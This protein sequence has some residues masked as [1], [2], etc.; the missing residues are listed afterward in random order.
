M[1]MK[2]MTNKG[3]GAMEYLMT[4]GW[5]I[6]VV[7]IVGVVL[8]QLGIFNPP[9]GTVFKNF[10]VLQPLGPSVSYKSSGN[11]FTMALSNNQ[12]SSIKISGVLINETLT[13]TVCNAISVNNGTAGTFGQTVAAGS[14]FSV[15]ATCALA[16]RNRADPY[17]MLVEVDYIA[18]IGGIMTPHTEI[19]EVRGQSE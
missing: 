4:Y 18:V 2:K 5:A 17:N 7:M 12:G 1:N 19:G 9:T 15:S 6:L 10:K 11:T 16:T 3:Q 8:W 13:T 14:A